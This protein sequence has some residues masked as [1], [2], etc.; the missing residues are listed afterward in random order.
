MKGVFSPFAP[1]NQPL[2][3]RFCEKIV[4]KSSI[5]RKILKRAFFTDSRHRGQ[6]YRAGVASPP[7]VTTYGALTEN[8]AAVL[9]FPLPTMAP[10]FVIPSPAS[11]GRRRR[12]GSTALIK[13]T[14][15]VS[16]AFS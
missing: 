8:A 11:A 3:E 10:H 4:T 7:D 5:L 1:G 16:P 13:K 12:Q 2:T 9:I 14:P 15:G 6:R